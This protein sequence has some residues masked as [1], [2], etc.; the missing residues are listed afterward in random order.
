[1]CPLSMVPLSK[2]NVELR[3]PVGLRGFL[4]DRGGAPRAILSD[5]LRETLSFARHS[6]HN[7]CLHE[8]WPV[9]FSDRCAFLFSL[10]LLFEGLLLLSSFCAMLLLP[11]IGEGLGSVR[12]WWEVLGAE[13]TGPHS[14]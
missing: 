1:M 10:A 7:V 5:P 12:N 3:L 13:V 14:G 2:I 6:F 9:G 8:N 4:S 11:D